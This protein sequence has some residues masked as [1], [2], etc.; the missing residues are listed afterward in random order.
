MRVRKIDPV[1][2]RVF[3]GSQAAFWINNA[4][5]VAQNVK[6]RLGLWLGQWWLNQA[7]GTPWSTDVLGKYTE[8]TRDA[9]VRARILGTPGVTGIVNYSS[10]LDRF[11]RKWNVDLTV[12]TLYGQATIA[13]PI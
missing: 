1:S 6:T 10:S 11:S 3:G 8:Q 12:N 7:D 9:V 4:E 13:G 5:G 2:G